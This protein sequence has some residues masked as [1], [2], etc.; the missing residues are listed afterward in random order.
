MPADPALPFL[1]GL[2]VFTIEQIRVLARFFATSTEMNYCLDRIAD[3]SGD[4][5]KNEVDRALM[6]V[7]NA[8]DPSQLDGESIAP[9]SERS[10]AAIRAACER[11]GV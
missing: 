5:L 11:A 3:A 8:L 1:A 7:S 2:D 4:S 6:K 9:V 10:Q